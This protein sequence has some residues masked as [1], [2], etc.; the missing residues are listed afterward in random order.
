MAKV[1]EFLKEYMMKIKNK[2]HKIKSLEETYESLSIREP[3]RQYVVDCSNNNP[4]FY[5]WLFNSEDD[6]FVCPDEDT[7]NEFLN[8]LK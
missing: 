5:R 1:L 7:F 8:E 4:N 6:D 3:F 2:E